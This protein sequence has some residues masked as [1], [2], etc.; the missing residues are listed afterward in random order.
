MVS[1]SQTPHGGGHVHSCWQPSLI[2]II[3]HGKAHKF[4]STQWLFQLQAPQ[5]HTATLNTNMAR[6]T[7]ALPTLRCHL[8]VSPGTALK[9]VMPMQQAF[10]H[11]ASRQPCSLHF[12]LCFVPQTFSKVYLEVYFTKYK[13]FFVVLQMILDA[14]IYK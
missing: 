5:F 12:N 2:I 11:P 10:T 4:Q 8:H 1:L 13:I 14:I 9:F 6:A 7:R 3:F